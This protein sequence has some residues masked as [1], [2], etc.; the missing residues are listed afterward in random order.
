MKARKRNADDDGCK[1]DQWSLD[2]YPF[3]VS[4]PVDLAAE[5]FMAPGCQDL[6]ALIRQLEI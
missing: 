5:S 2:S 6:T 3:N 1:S 4:C